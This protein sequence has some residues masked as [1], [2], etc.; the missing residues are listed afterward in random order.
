MVSWSG[1]HASKQP[2]RH[3]KPAVSS[4]LPLFQD[5]AK[6]VAMIRHSMNIVKKATEYLNPG[7]FQRLLLINHRLPWQS[8]YSGTGQKPTVSQTLLFYLVVYVRW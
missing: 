4:L 5:E 2:Q 6:S 1:Y 3:L 7:L 8:K